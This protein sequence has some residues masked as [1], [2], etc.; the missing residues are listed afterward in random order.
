MLFN[1]SLRKHKAGQAPEGNDALQLS[2]LY[3][4]LQ[5]VEKRL[6]ER[7]SAYNTISDLTSDLKGVEKEL[8]EMR[9]NTRKSIDN[10]TVQLNGYA[11]LFRMDRNRHGGCVLAYVK[12]DIFCVRRF[13]YE[14]DD[15]EILRLELKTSNFRCLYI[16]MCYLPPNFNSLLKHRL[17]IYCIS[18]PSS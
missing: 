3:K 5:S 4:L 9:E 18:V 8:T 17:P 6:S 11:D 10:V 12:N 1:S 13:D 2:D 16:A 14:S 7:L 15:V